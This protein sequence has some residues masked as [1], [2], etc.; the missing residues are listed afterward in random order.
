MFGKRKKV[1]LKKL[2]E[3]LS[4]F[5][6]TRFYTDNWADYEQHLDSSEHD[7]SKQNTQR[8]ER[9]RLHF[10]TRIKRLTRRTICFAKRELMHDI[11]IALYI[12]TVEFGIDIHEKMQN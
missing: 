7:I 3:H 4:P 9:K 10:R 5:A 11:V 6:I 1:V 2:K 8:I 12:N